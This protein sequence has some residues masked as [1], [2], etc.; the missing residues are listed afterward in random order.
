MPL[1]TSDTHLCAFNFIYSETILGQSSPVSGTS[2][3]LDFS[4]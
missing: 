4:R 2:S 1:S 3:L